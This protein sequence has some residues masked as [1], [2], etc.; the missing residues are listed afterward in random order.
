[1]RRPFV[2]IGL[3]LVFALPAPAAA[4]VP[5]KRCAISVDPG[6]G[7]PRDVYRIT[8]RHF[9]LDK[10]GEVSRLQPGHYVVAAQTPHQKG[11]HT[12]SGFDVIRG[13]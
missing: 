5:T 10:N 2:L 8:G 12:V 4:H 7:G 11:C 6:R 9:P 3:A 1:M 13:G